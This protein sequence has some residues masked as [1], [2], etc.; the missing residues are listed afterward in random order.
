MHGGAGRGQKRCHGA[1]KL[2]LYT[3]SC[4]PPDTGAGS[5]NRSCVSRKCSQLLSLSPGPLFF[6]HPFCSLREVARQPKGKAM[7]ASHSVSYYFF[8]DFSSFIFLFHSFII[9]CHCLLL[10]SQDRNNVPLRSIHFYSSAEVCLVRAQPHN[11][12][13]VSLSYLSRKP[14]FRS[15]PKLET[16]HVLSHH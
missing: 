16:P 2:D 14:N 9:L 4:E 11:C 3:D 10:S 12:K 8:Q 5:K 7:A 6:T 15:M 1:P 13:E